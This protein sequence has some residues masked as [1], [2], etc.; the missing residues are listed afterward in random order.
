MSMEQAQASRRFRWVDAFAV[1]LLTLLGAAGEALGYDRHLKSNTSKQR[2]L[3][4]SL[5]VVPVRGNAVR[6][7][8]CGVGAFSL[9][10]NYVLTA[11][12]ARAGPL[13]CSRS[14]VA[15]VGSSTEGPLYPMTL[16]LSG[17]PSRKAERFSLSCRQASGERSA[18]IF[19]EPLDR[20]N[21][22]DVHGAI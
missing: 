18:C 10:N 12:R 21:G 16:L 15:S 17:G 4:L 19:D 5:R 22:K 1:V 9:V 7:L 8:G 11:D 6:T 13:S 14:R 2:C 3:P 20:R